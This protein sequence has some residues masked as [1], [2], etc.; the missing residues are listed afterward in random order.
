[1]DARR[2]IGKLISM[3]GRAELNCRPHGPEPCV[4]PTELR[5]DTE[6]TNELHPDMLVFY[7]KNGYNRRVFV[8]VPVAQLD[9]AGVS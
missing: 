7:H 9:R 1:M 6:I 2:I 4:L 3:S 8:H 5:P